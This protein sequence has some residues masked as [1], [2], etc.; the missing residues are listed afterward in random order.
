MGRCPLPQKGSPPQPARAGRPPELHCSQRRSLL[1]AAS[2][3]LG[4]ARGFWGCLGPLR[5]Q[6]CTRSGLLKTKECAQG[7]WTP[8]E[9]TGEDAGRVHRPG[10]GPQ[11]PLRPRRPVGHPASCSRPGHL[12][13][14]NCTEAPHAPGAP[15]SAAGG[16]SRPLGDLESRFPPGL[17]AAALLTRM[18]ASPAGRSHAAWPQG[19]DKPSSP[20]SGP[21]VTAHVLGARR[22]R[23]LHVPGQSQLA[24]ARQGS[25]PS[26]QQKNLGNHQHPARAPR[27]LR[28]RLPSSLS[29]G[30]GLRKAGQA[31]HCPERS[32]CLGTHTPSDKVPK[33][34]FIP[35]GSP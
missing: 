33:S 7:E 28:P 35:Q 18:P 30:L 23:P 5:T 13:S 32:G 9:W 19:C 15:R 11:G 24:R 8:G 27:A 34:R 21:S 12:G 4:W 22:A 29:R 1:L 3:A 20:P 2:R 16:T 17:E 10:R 14:R 6:P 26:G 25:C 31:G